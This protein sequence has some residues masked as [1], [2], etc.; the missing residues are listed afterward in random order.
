MVP[1]AERA[2]L[3]A[4]VLAFVRSAQR[5]PGIMRI[6]LIGS[7]TTDKAN[8]EDAD[9]LVTVTDDMDLTPL[10]SLSR[11]MLGHAQSMNLGVD[12]FLTD[13]HN[14]YLGRICL[15]KECAPG[16]RMRCD[17]LHCGRRH[18][19][20]DDLKDIKLAHSVIA[21]PPLELWPEVVAR[22]PLPQDI[23]QRLL[24]PIKGEKA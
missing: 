7:L 18:Y 15:W 22:V 23:E 20:H 14:K 13:P 3:I 11:K 21:A 12:V 1:G 8:P 19:L 9:L 6:A 17:A 16:I 24:F 5:W 2:R 4:E 10:A